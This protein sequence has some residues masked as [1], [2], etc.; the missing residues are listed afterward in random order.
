[1]VRNINRNFPA[2]RWLVEV[3]AADAAST[4]A[5]RLVF[6]KRTL[7]LLDTHPCNA[8][9]PGI[10]FADDGLFWA[11]CFKPE[12][13]NMTRSINSRVFIFAYPFCY[14]KGVNGLYKVS[15][16]SAHTNIIS[17]S[18][19]NIVRNGKINNVEKRSNYSF[20]A[21][22]RKRTGFVAYCFHQHHRRRRVI[23]G[24]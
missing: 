24:E 20:L 5:Y 10:N 11:A 3:L 15:K 17:T 22:H 21:R 1:M 6:V 13:K 19:Q 23:V 14:F 9:V 8:A 2:G 7:N 16:S 18:E 4:N 12:K